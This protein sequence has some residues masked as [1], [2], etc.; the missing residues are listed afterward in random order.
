MNAS[1]SWKPSRQWKPSHGSGFAVERNGSLGYA[2][3]TLP[4]VEKLAADLASLVGA[5]VPSVEIEDIDHI[6]ECAIS[7]VKNAHSRP[8]IDMQ[9][10]TDT[11]RQQ[12]LRE[13]SGLLPFLAWIDATDHYSEANY[14]LERDDYGPARL[15]AIDFEH[16][17]SWV[18]GQDK[19]FV[20]SPGEFIKAMDSRRVC[21]MVSRIETLTA[22]QINDCCNRIGLPALAPVLILRQGLLRAALKAQGWPV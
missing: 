3:T 13:A 9:G 20:R 4:K 12:A 21:E 2:K 1:S 5:P 16:A 15:V 11:E 18:Q 7:Y 10:K 17:F 19:I 8:L 6:G 22:Q 14:V